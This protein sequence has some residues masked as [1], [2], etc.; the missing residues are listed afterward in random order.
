M[1]FNRTMNKLFTLLIIGSISGL[2]FLSATSQQAFAGGRPGWNPCGYGETFFC[3]KKV[4]PHGIPHFTPPPVTCHIDK[5]NH[6]SAP[7]VVCFSVRQILTN[8]GISF[9][10]IR[11][12]LDIL[13]CS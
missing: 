8:G 6:C 3:H 2:V 11:Q 7:I 13:N 4:V 5:Y 12:V 10:V 1:R 9:D